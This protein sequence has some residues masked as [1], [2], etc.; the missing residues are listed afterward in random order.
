MVIW[1]LLGNVEYDLMTDGMEK[2]SSQAQHA[3]FG[4]IQ[5][6]LI[7]LDYLQLDIESGKGLVVKYNGEALELPDMYW[8]MV[9][10][11]DGRYVEKLLEAAGVK[12]LIPLGEIDA[13]RCKV[14]SYGR[15]AKAG[16]P[17]PRSRIFFKETDL[18]GV[19]K[20][21]GYP[22]VVKP[23]GGHGGFGVELINNED[24]LKKCKE[25]LVQGETYIA[26]EYVAT[27]KGKDLRVVLVNGEIL[28]AITRTNSNPDEFRSNLDQGGVQQ[29]ITPDDKVS[30]LAKKAAALFDMPLLSVDFMYTETGYTIVE[31]NAFPGTITKPEEQQM[32]L[33]GVMK[34]YMQHQKA[35]EGV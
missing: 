32:V 11:T 17:F 14:L 25:N 7:W 10:N 26:Q 13:A 29:D 35:A 20:D 21:L 27:S 24:E 23:N 5:L 28:N 3:S 6:K 22:F 18:N 19:V 9:G 8:L 34:Y 2:L 33:K 4:D 12:P 15:L 1:G 16:L 31:V 30:E